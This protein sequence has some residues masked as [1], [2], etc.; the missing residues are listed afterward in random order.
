LFFLRQGTCHSLYT[1]LSQ[2]GWIS[3]DEQDHSSSD[4][5]ED[6]YTTV[7]WNE[8]EDQGKKALG[9]TQDTPGQ[10]LSVRQLSRGS[11]KSR[12]IS[13]SKLPSHFCSLMGDGW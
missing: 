8:T 9:V 4:A 11:D 10:L 1:S 2:K 13:M 7:E 12:D 3:A 6:G 5:K